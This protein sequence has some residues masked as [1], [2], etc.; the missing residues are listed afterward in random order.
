MR[1]QD[2]LILVVMVLVTV[3]VIAVSGGS[4]VAIIALAVGWVI[5]LAAMRKERAAR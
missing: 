3:A 5:Y 1:T 2:I 4:I